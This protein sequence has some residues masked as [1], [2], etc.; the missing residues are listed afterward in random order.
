MPG[1]KRRVFLLGL[2]RGLDRQERN[3]ARILLYPKFEDFTRLSPAMRRAVDFAF[4]HGNS[5]YILLATVGGQ[6]G[7][8]VTFQLDPGRFD[9]ESS[10]RV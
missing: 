5:A 3:M 9:L 8:E 4:K 10:G 1:L 2:C 7:E 6:A